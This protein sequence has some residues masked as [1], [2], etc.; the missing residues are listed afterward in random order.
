VTPADI[1][2]AAREYFKPTNETVV[3]LAHKA[4]APAAQGKPGGAHHD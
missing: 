3:T 4:D 1:Q 2:R